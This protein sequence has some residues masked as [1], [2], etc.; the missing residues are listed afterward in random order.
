MFPVLKQCYVPTRGFI[1]VNIDAI[2]LQVIVSM[3]A[4]SGVNTVFITDHFPELRE[5][6]QTKKIVSLSDTV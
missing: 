5:K 4:A 2:Q 6:K 3:V 1:V